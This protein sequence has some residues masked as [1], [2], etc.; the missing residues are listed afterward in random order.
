VVAKEIKVRPED[1]MVRRL[2][3]GMRNRVAVHVSR[4]SRM[5]ILLPCLSVRKRSKEFAL[6]I[7]FSFTLVHCTYVRVTETFQVSVL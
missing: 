4:T 5:W 3:P 7:S 1:L 2:R 6:L